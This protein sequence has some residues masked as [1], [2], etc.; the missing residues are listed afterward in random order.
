MPLKHR[1][2][3][4]FIIVWAAKQRIRRLIRPVNAQ[5]R[6]KGDKKIVEKIVS[7]VVISY[8]AI[9]HFGP[10]E[11]VNPCRVGGEEL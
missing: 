1:V 7:R 10:E 4:Q 11:V 9:S 8:E 3:H 5:R 6:R 2:N